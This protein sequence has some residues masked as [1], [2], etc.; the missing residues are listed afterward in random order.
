MGDDMR[1]AVIEAPGKVRIESAPLPE[2][3]P[4]QVRVRLEGS[5]VC[6]STL[7]LW[8]GRPWFRYPVEGGAPGGAPDRW[9]E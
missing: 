7:A 8:E 1:V 5:G 6:A 9:R 2:P 4:G 3:G